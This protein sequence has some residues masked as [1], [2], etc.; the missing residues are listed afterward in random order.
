VI[1]FPLAKQKK[2]GIMS[3]NFSRRQKTQT[4]VKAIGAPIIRRKQKTQT[5][6]NGIAPPK[7]SLNDDDRQRQRQRQVHDVR[8]VLDDRGV[9]GHVNAFLTPEEQLA[10]RSLNTS[11]QQVIPLTP[12]EVQTL[13]VDRR[14]QEVVRQVRSGTA[15]RDLQQMWRRDHEV[16]LAAVQQDGLALEFASAELRDDHEIVLAAVQQNV[17]ALQYASVELYGDREFMLAAV[18]Q[19]DDALE[20][21]S[22]ELRGDREFVLAVVQQNGR[23]LEYADDELHGDR[24]IVLAAVQQ[25]GRALQSASAELR[26]DDDIVLAAV[27]QRGFAL[28]YA[29]P[30]LR[31]DPEMKR[32]ARLNNIRRKRAPHAVLDYDLNDPLLDEDVVDWEDPDLRF[33]MSKKPHTHPRARVSHK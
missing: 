31:G 11:R 12:D 16:V 30:K 28:R 33:S 7:K 26:D 3:V 6:G 21:A 22:A 20:Y 13:R 15:L 32:E 2:K 14:R 10:M 9:F 5:D 29:S 24:E 19:D 18:Q 23:A 8:P 4:D 1:F 27:Q 17:Q 25:N